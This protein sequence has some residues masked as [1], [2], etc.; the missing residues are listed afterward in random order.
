ML[1]DAPIEDEPEN[2]N[3]NRKGVDMTETIA[4]FQENWVNII[5][6]YTGMVTVASIVVKMTPTLK[7]DTVLLAITK[8]I[9]K[10]IARNTS[11]PESRPK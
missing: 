2:F 10:Y 7:D 3:A 6:V 11:A 8:F 4:R 9:A 1:L 5:A